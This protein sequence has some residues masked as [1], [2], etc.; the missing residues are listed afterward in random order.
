[1]LKESKL[2]FKY[3]NPFGEQKLNKVKYYT[4]SHPLI[5]IIDYKNYI[6]KRATQHNYAVNGICIAQRVGYSEELLELLIK[7]DVKHDDYEAKFQVNK[8]SKETK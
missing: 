3:I 8:L 7:Y 1:M 6:I 4:A 5:H 2:N